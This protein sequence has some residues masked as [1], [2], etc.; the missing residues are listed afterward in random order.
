MS[1]RDADI[2]LAHLSDISPSQLRRYKH[3]P[4]SNAEIAEIIDLRLPSRRLGQ[5][6][7]GQVWP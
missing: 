3:S 5:A 2:L 7:E 1:K 4:L 6:A